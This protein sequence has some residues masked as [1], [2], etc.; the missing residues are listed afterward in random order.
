MPNGLWII[1]LISLKR[2][3]S[4]RCGFRIQLSDVTFGARDQAKKLDHP[5][6]A[7]PTE[8]TKIG[9]TPPKKE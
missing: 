8:V 9:S 7:Q 4:W 2:S 1:L 5:M 3:V 6:L